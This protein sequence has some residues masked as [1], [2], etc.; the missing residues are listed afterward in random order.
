MVERDGHRVTR[1]FDWLVP[2]RF[3]DLITLTLTLRVDGVSIARHDVIFRPFT[4]ET[5]VDELH[6]AGLAEVTV[7]QVP[8]RRPVRRDRPALTPAAGQP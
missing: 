3:G 1:R 8:G 2:E 7:T 6:A 4:T 5:L